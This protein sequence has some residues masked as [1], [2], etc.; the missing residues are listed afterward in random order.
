[1]A[2][3]EVAMKTRW[4]PFNEWRERLINENLPEVLDD[5]DTLHG[6][7]TRKRRTRGRLRIPRSVCGAMQSSLRTV[8]DVG[9]ANSNSEGTVREDEE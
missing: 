9:S 5:A 8:G 6:V 1:M 4:M 3:K 7:R 2:T